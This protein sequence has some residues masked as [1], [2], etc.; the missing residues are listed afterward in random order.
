MPQLLPQIG[1]HVI[2]IIK[3]YTNTNFPVAQYEQIG[4]KQLVM[5]V[6]DQ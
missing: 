5:P 2:K 4:G 3:Y 1:G 6:V